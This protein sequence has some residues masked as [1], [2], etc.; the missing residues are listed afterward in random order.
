MVSLSTVA[1][2]YAVWTW[3]TA[4]VYSFSTKKPL[5]SKNNTQFSVSDNHSHTH[6][7]QCG[8]FLRHGCQLALFRPPS[9]SPS[10]CCPSQQYKPL[11]ID[12]RAVSLQGQSPPLSS[13]TTSTTGQLHWKQRRASEALGP[14]SH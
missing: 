5:Q 9:S 3:K 12:Q 11:N 10:C 13:T 7:F 8:C 1:H 6:T 2:L 4:T 14:T